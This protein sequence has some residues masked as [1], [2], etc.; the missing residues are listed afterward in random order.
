MF[1][2]IKCF[3]QQSCVLSCAE[4]VIGCSGPMH[5]SPTIYGNGALFGVYFL[6]V[7]DIIDVSPKTH[8]FE[9]NY[10]SQNYPHKYKNV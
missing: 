10:V 3:E 6:C 2:K 1:V 7:T 5:P 9:A 4:M 8:L